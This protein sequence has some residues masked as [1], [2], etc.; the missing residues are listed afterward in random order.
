MLEAIAN[1]LTAIGELIGALEGDN[2]NDTDQ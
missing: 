1:L 2:S